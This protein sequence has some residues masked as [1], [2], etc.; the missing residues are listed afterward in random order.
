MQKERF[1]IFGGTFDPPHLGH[2]ILACE[3]RFQLNLTRLLWVLTPVPPHKLDMRITPLEH[4]F[5][6]LQLAIQDNPHFEVSRVEIERPGPHYAVDT[7]QII[8]DENPAA[9]IIYLMGGDSLRDLS[10]WH[11]PTDFV[12]TC[13]EIGVMRRPGNSIDLR[14]LENALPGLTSKVCF[15]DA[16][17]LEISS[18]QIRRRAAKEWPICY[19]LPP[20]VHAYIQKN[21]IYSR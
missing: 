9:E 11:R 13:H 5:D 19:Y 20:Q 1:G 21:G 15:V 18:R 16:P 2:L 14:T 17:L 6:M 10:S 8:Q 12:S 3:I 4:R 7:V